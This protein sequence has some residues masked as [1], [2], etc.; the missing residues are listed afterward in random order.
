MRVKCLAQ[1][2]HTMSPARAR[3]ERTNRA[4]HKRDN[5]FSSLALEYSFQELI[6][7]TVIRFHCF[8]LFTKIITLSI[9]KTSINKKNSNSS[10]S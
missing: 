3:T 8:T 2:Q 10:V 6:E 5:L 4:S 1:E 7:P 9:N